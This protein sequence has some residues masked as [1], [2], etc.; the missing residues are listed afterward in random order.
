VGCECELEVGSTFE[1]M[2]KIRSVVGGLFTFRVNEK[3]LENVGVHIWY[4][5][6]WE[7]RRATCGIHQGRV[8]M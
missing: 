3:D 7:Q 6:Y 5:Y 2:R 4:L 8:V 1:R